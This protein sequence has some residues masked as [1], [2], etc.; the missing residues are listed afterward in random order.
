LDGLDARTC[1]RINR[2]PPSIEINLS[3]VEVI[4][5]LCSI[6]D[7]GVV[8]DQVTLMEVPIEIVRAAEH[9]ERGRED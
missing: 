4:Y 6:D 3:T 1:V 8:Y 9:E 7:S 5:D 2:S